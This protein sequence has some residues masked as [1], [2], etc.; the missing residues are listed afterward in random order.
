MMRVMS[1]TIS[2]RGLSVVLLGGLVGLAAC[3][4]PNVVSGTTTA[5]D[6]TGGDT[7]GDTVD[8]FRTFFIGESVSLTGAGHAT[9]RT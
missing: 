8:D 1:E 5:G 6:D 4:D 2:I 3:P 9:T 7:G